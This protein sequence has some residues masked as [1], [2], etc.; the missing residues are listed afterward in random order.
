VE[1][2]GDAGRYGHLRVRRPATILLLATALGIAASSAVAAGSARPAVTAP[3]ACGR[4]PHRA[5][6]IRHVIVVVMENASYSQVIG[7]GPFITALAKRCGRATNYHGVSHPSL[8]NYLAMTSGS[9]HGI[10]TDCMPTACP[11]RGPSI[12][13]QLS[14]HH[15]NWRSYAESMPAACSMRGTGLYAP[16]HVPAVYYLRVRPICRRHVRS[17]GRAGSGRM[18]TALNS[19]HA[20]SYMFVTP[21]LCSDM[22]DCPLAKGD[23]WLARWIPMMVRSRTYRHGHTAILV[24]WDEG[25]GANRVP[26]VVV[27]PYTPAGRVSSR[28]FTHFSLL[29]ATEGMLGIRRHLGKAGIS[30]G[31]PKAFHL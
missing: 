30:R 5:P 11:Q 18:H 31:L 23:A 26:L 1:A 24:V 9:T 16:R 2:R 17:L 19:G 6:V 4:T 27:S 7:H 29:R 10:R 20:P 25:G 12:F 15:L 3:A 21:N 13:S 8:P 22:H 28:H 14:H